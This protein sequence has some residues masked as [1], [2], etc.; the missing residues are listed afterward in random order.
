MDNIQVFSKQKSHHAYETYIIWWSTVGVKFIIC[1]AKRRLV[2]QST[3]NIDYDIVQHDLTAIYTMY[4]YTLYSHVYTPL[5]KLSSAFN[6]THDWDHSYFF[7]YV[8]IE[9]FARK[10]HYPPKMEN[11][12]SGG[13]VLPRSG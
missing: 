7:S 2:H 10:T 5:Q 12:V 11:Q 3:H 1:F 13:I 4:N 8:I 6:Y 9:G